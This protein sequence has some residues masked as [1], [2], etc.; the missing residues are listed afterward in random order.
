MTYVVDASVVIQW[1]AEEQGSA[2][3][4]SLMRQP[5]CAPELLLAECANA[6]WKKVVR[7]EFSEEEA[8]G[9]VRA[10]GGAGITFESTQSLAVDILALSLRLKHPAYD[11]V[12]LALARKLDGLLVTADRRLLER[13]GQPDAAD[14]ARHVRALDRIPGE[15]QEPRTRKYRYR[16]RPAA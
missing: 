12:Y 14:V 6:L 8:L 11:C 10:I 2:N 16:V 3:A 9:A 15:L 13:C 1:L 4:A 7:G 5:V